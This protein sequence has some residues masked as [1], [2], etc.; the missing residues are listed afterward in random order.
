[1][2][3][4]ALIDKMVNIEESLIQGE[5]RDRIKTNQ[6]TLNRSIYW[7]AFIKMVKLLNLLSCNLFAVI[8]FPVFF[9]TICFLQSSLNS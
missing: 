1:M 3:T 6:I 2:T 9:G 7:T 8:T 4:I 5:I